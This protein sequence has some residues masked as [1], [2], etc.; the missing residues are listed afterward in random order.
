MVAERWCTGYRVDKELVA[1]VVEQA[2]ID[3]TEPAASEAFRR[4]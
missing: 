4:L 1:S 2:A 3:M